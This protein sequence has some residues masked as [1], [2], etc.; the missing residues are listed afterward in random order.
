MKNIGLSKFDKIKQIGS[1]ENYIWL[2]AR[3]SYVKLDHSSSIMIGIYPIPDEL[4]IDWSSG[5]YNGESQ[6]KQIF[7]NYRVLDGWMLNGDEF[8]DRIGRRR[9]ITTGFIGQ[10]GNVYAGS[11][12]GIVFYG[13]KTMETFTPLVPDVINDD[14]LSLYMRDNYLWIGSQNFLKSKGISKLDV[15]SL[16][17]FYYTFEETINMQPTSVYS[18]YDSGNEMWAGG[19]GIILYF[20]KSKN[21]WKTLDES[22]GIPGGIIWDLC[23]TDRFLWMG[24]SEG[25]KRIEIATHSVDEIGIEQYFDN[26]H[27]YSVENIDNEIWIGSRSGLFIYSNEDPKL[28]NA[29]NFPKKELFSNFYNI[30]VIQENDNEVYVAGDMGIANFNIQQKEWELISVPGVYGNEMVYSMANNEK[31]LFLG[32][33]KGLYRINKISGLVRDYHYSFIGQVNDII[34]EDN[35]IWLGTINGLLKFKWKRDL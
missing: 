14:V 19:D 24:S 11:E 25:L 15:K 9:K 23:V 22:R 30:T 10:H 34:L 7:T 6:L 18:I 32:T 2:K 20:N 16:E 26:T 12:D 8:I 31:F 1:T 5:E 17:S 4:N 13:T 27:V 28:I 29:F 3:S 35:I 33:T 21:F